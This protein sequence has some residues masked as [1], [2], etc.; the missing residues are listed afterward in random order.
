MEQ[1]ALD[2]IRDRNNFFYGIVICFSSLASLAGEG[3]IEARCHTVV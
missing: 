3:T 2:N 1:S